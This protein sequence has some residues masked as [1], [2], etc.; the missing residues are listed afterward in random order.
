METRFEPASFEPRWQ[1]E[2]AERGW[3]RA[4]ARP[5]RR[6][7]CIPIPPPN[8][9][10]KL[11][12]GHA[13]QSTLQDLL[14]RWRRMQ[15]WDALWLP[16]TDHAGIA[17]QLMVER[18]LESQGSGRLE[19]GR[20]KF[21]ERVWAWKEKYHD[22]IRRQL[23]AMG[24]SC[25]WTRERF[26]LDEGLSRAVR[27]AFVRLHREGLI[28]R[29]EYLVNWSTG[30]DTA[31]SDLEVEMRSVEDRLWHIAYPIEGS[32]ERVV[33]ATTRPETMLGDV[34]IAYHPE[35]E[36]YQRFAQQ[37]AVV[38]VAG[39][40][41][42]FVADAVVEREFGSGLVKVTPSHDPADFEIGRRHELTGIQVIDR[43][44][45]MTAAAGEAFAGLTVDEAREKLLGELRAGGFLVREEKYVHNVGFCQRSGARVE[46]LVSTQWFCD[47]S[48]MAASA[49]DVWRR[50]E[51]EFVPE[52][53][54]KTWEHWLTGIRPWCISRQLWWGHQIP[55]WYDEAGRVFVAHDRAEAEKLAGTDRL[56]QDEDV[57]D[58]WFSS[59]L[60]PFSTLGW[61]DESHPDYRAFYPTAVLVTGFDIL[62]FW[63]ARMVMTGLH[64]TGRT[65]FARVHLT[66]LVRDAEGQKMSKT[67]GNVLDPVELIAEYGADAM[68][69]T[70]A[71]LD[72]PGR[73]IPLDPERMAGYRA[74]GNKIWNAA[75]FALTKGAGGRVC[76][77][78]A[79]ETAGLEL[80]ERWILHRFEET[81]V[82]VTR[83]LEAF[84]F[85]LACR[86]V[87]QFVW[88]DFCDWYIEMAKPGLA[89]ESAR[90]RVA[91]VLVTVLERALRLLH[92]VMP[93]VTEELWQRLPGREAIHP[94]TICL[95]PWPA[96]ERA[97]ALAEADSERIS[98]LRALA[99]VVRNDRAERGLPPK[100]SAT[101]H[102]DDSAKEQLL[103]EY[104][105]SPEL[106]A[107]LGSL[108]RVSRIEAGLPPGG[109]GHR[110][111][112]LGVSFS[113]VFEQA[114]AGI[115]S[116][117]V[118]AELAEIEA[119]VERVRS[120]LA[121]PGFA[122]KAPAAVV[123]GARRQLAELEERRQ[124]LVAVV[125]PA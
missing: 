38:P 61:P 89:G 113:P 27:E 98:F 108:C 99:L 21:L 77:D 93:H 24:A 86:D 105:R 76:P 82:E 74:F 1:A 75:R 101:I 35:D 62:F 48:G 34:A 91:D 120:R 6:P 31:I 118:A 68:R 16:G 36:R 18:E 23:Q 124:R 73:D 125:G 43:K 29:G 100:T 111:V 72:A 2:W 78:L 22:N 33:V 44:G 51:L 65:P 19:L 40:T 10:G 107:L 71:Q 115:D 7:Y 15:G 45:R 80:P 88:S 106:L 20:E 109:T 26:T 39:R 119:L 103:V 85:D 49:L 25:D 4:T 8:V 47:V 69:F 30:L 90:P 63:V 104:L 117:K 97:P 66:G 92:P 87:Y 3:F 59:A 46:P 56:R 53:W 122:D 96:A 114:A 52:S 9:T 102:F 123:E 12:M 67:K 95:A 13:L 60:W 14:T 37:R 94:E 83:A 50:G 81:A 54:G 110:H 79:P 84:R 17:T 55:A 42:P 41:I 32:Q 28:T 112:R 64:F 116:A 11:H 121:N 58:T 5:G 57:L 70:L